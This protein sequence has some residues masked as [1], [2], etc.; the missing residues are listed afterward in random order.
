MWKNLKYY[1][2]LML[3]CIGC[4]LPIAIFNLPE[5]ATSGA[6][7]LVVFFAGGGLAYSLFKMYFEEYQGEMYETDE[8]LANVLSLIFSIISVGLNILVMSLYK[9]SSLF[10]ILNFLNEF[11]GDVGEFYLRLATVIFSGLSLF[12]LF[13]MAVESIDT[14]IYDWKRTTY[15]NGKPVKSEIVSHSCNE[16]KA[17]YFFTTVLVG[18]TAVVG[19]SLSV[20][21]IVLGLNIGSFING[22]AKKIPQI[23]GVIGALA[24]TVVA[25]LGTLNGATAN[26]D[27][28]I[29]VAGQ[30]MPIVFAGLV[31]LFFIIYFKVEFL[32]RVLPLILAV[33]LMIF[34]SWIVSFFAARLVNVIYFALANPV[35]IV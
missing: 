1:M 16:S 20:A 7:A 22:K 27:L 32:G 30:L 26:V 13:L 28:D 9:E 19:T 34:A 3:M 15:I 31:V 2:S 12:P 6:G 5:E 17:A 33:F 4:V 35:P 14:A 29:A 10:G 21:I 8:R 23:L 18:M 11:S 24:V 25:V